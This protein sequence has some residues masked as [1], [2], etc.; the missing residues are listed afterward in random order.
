MY[1]I[2]TNFQFFLVVFIA[3]IALIFPARADVF[4]AWKSG[5]FLYTSFEQPERFCEAL[6]ELQSNL[7]LYKPENNGYESPTTYACGQNSNY[8]PQV[9]WVFLKTLDCPSGQIPDLGFN[10]CTN[11]SLIGHDD[12][13]SSCSSPST[14]AGNPI[15]FTYGNKIQNETDFESSTMK[16]S[17]FYN[18]YDGL[19]RHNFSTR[20]YF[21][22]R[23][24]VMVMPDG[25]EH[26]FSPSAVGFTS[27]TDIGVLRKVGDSWHYNGIDQKD[28][29]FSASGELTQVND[30][31]GITYK[32]LRKRLFAGQEITITNSYGESVVLVESARHK[33]Q[34]I[35][36]PTHNI[37][38]LYDANQNLSE[39]KVS[40]GRV[41]SIRRYH[42]E[43]DYFPTSLTGITDERGVRFATWAYDRAGRA[44]SS[45]RANNT[46]ITKIVYKDDDSRIVT[47]EL[48]KN[49][50]YRYKT[51]SGVMRLVE[52]IGEPSPN[53]PASNSSYTYNERGQVLTKTDARGYI[54]AYTYNDRGLETNR[55]E[56]SGTAQA[57]TVITEWGPFPAPP[58]EDYRTYTNHRIYLRRP[59]QGNRPASHSTMTC[60][61]RLDAF[62]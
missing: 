10:H 54:T 39:R 24:A 2:N 8:Q 5:H 22:D 62:N 9:G 12:H 15:N 29:I 17:R 26:L 6:Y 51:I 34:S 55:T 41:S 11:K 31:K 1:K 43:N 7:S 48:G 56:A 50:I 42:Y 27:N 35:K 13:F 58:Y 28:L 16:I 25:N 45:Q 36:T 33:L 20:L 53:C 3:Q 4:T 59:R 14:L 30:L 21:S 32:L 19:W 37:V 18:S 47:N 40:S 46:G 60:L 52:I 61:V 38:F 23:S 57:Q 49:T 44:I